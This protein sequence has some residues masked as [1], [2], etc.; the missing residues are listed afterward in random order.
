MFEDAN[1]EETKVLYTY[2]DHWIYGKSTMK[3]DL[4]MGIEFVKGK[5][6]GIEL[7]MDSIAHMP[8][9][10]KGPSGIDLNNAR[11]YISTCARSL[12]A[13]YLHLPEAAPTN[14]ND[15]KMVGKSLT[16]LVTDFIKNT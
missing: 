10:A 7:D 14:K 15:E 9:S 6:V 2:F 4:E 1:Q 8:S 3:K 16:Y 5:N 11:E 13:A 12:N